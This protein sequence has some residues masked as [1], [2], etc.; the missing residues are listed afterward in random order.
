VESGTSVVAN[1]LSLFVWTYD[2][3]ATRN[4]LTVDGNL[5]INTTSLVAP[6]HTDRRLSVGGI[7]QTTD[8]TAML[9][10]Q[11]AFGGVMNGVNSTFEPLIRAFAKER[12][13]TGLA[14][15]V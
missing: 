3:A 6:N 10:G 1:R 4:Q 9:N 2:S 15:A 7:K 14:H 11:F 8:P 13:P 12:F 5:V